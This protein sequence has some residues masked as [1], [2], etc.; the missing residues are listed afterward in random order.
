MPD[1]LDFVSTMLADPEVMRFYPKCYSREEAQKWLT[2]QIDRYARDGHGLWLVAEKSDGRPVGQVGLMIQ[3]VDGVDEPEIGY[4]IHRPFWR[5]GFAAEAAA[6]S[7]DYAFQRF[8]KPR[9]ISLVR[10]LNIPSLR[11]ALRIGMKPEKF[12]VHAN[13]D[14]LVFSISRAAV[15]Q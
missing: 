2:G 6:A 11:V 9:I 1:D 15:K 8:Q 14:H 10:P 4:L 12:T 3:Q 5:R 7:R 13:L